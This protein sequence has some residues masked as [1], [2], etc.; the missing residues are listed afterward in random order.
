[1]SIEPDWLDMLMDRGENEVTSFNLSMT[2]QPHT[3]TH[4]HLVLLFLLTG[5]QA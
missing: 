1:M 2:F 5:M 4:V 3:G